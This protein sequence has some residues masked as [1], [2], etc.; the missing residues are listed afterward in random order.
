MLKKYPKLE[1]NDGDHLVDLTGYVP[2]NSL[3]DAMIQTGRSLDMNR[4]K[5]FYQYETDDHPD[6]LD[7][8]PTTC[9]DFDVV[10]S[11]RIQ[12]FLDDKT[13]Q[14]KRDLLNQADLKTDGDTETPPGPVSPEQPP[15]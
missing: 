2:V 8:D 3:I 13:R 15:E 4:Q 12:E 14:Q 1:V 9:K 10:D 7:I 6:K 11:Q 5:M